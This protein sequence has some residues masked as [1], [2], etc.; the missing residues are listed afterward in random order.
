MSRRPNISAA[1]ARA[2]A[3]ASSGDVSSPAVHAPQKSQRYVTIACKLAVSRFELQLCRKQTVKENTQTG[4]R[5][6]EQYFKTGIVYVVRGT[7]YPE[8]T[9]PK[10]FFKRPEE[11]DGYAITENV[12]PSDFWDAWLEQYGKSDMVKN[13]LIF[14]AE[15]YDE[16]EGIGAEMIKQKCAF[17]PLDMPERDGEPVDTRVPRSVHDGVSTVEKA[18]IA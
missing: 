11:I 14:A 2:A 3:A 12:V 8:G 15:T 16:I 7:A 18:S 17:A 10:K 1:A 4:P 13:K 5:D 6:V 9:P